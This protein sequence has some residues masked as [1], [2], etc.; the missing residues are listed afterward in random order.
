MIPIHIGV[1]MKIVVAL[2]LAIVAIGDG[3]KWT[4]SRLRRKFA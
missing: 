3:K 2:L 4:W 1:K